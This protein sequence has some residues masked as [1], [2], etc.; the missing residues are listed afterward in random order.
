MKISEKVLIIQKL[1]LVSS[2]L[3]TE[4]DSRLREIF[5]M[6]PEKDF[7]GLSI[8]IV[9][10]LLQLPPARGKLLFSRLSDKNNM[11]HLLGLQ[12]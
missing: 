2:D 11:K 1:P 6:L 5:M 10:Q 9:A 7:A 8:M 4:V 3:W 12:L